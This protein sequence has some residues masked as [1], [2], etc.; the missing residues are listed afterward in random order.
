MNS[1][2]Y[3]TALVLLGSMI[4]S[5][6]TAVA[7]EATAHNP[8]YDNKGLW[9]HDVEKT[10]YFKQHWPK[11]TVMVWARTGG[12]PGQGNAR[13]RAELRNPSNWLIEEQLLP[14]RQ[15]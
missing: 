3:T 1:N 15:R 4:A 7:E 13:I 14:R 8:Q 5:T 11:A 6:T 9:P 12:D 2:H 10:D